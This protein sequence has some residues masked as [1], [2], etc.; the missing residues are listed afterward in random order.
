MRSARAVCLL[1]VVV[2]FLAAAADA[3]KVGPPDLFT[4]ASGALPLAFGV[5]GQ[6]TPIGFEQALDLIDGNTV[7]ASVLTQAAP[8]AGAWFLYELPAPTTFTRLAVPEVHETPSAFQTFFRDVVVAGC[9]DG[10]GTL[11]GTVSGP[12]LRARGVA[13]RTKT[14]QASVHLP[15]PSVPGGAAR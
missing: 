6:A 14:A 3:E 9:F 5:T 2:P 10:E 15:C 12:M 11:H 8:D 4:F 7:K 1:A 13:T